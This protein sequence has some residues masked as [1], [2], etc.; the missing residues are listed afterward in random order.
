MHTKFA[1]ALIRLGATNPE[2]RPHIRPLLAAVSIRVT[3]STIDRFRK[4]Q[5]FSTLKGAQAFAQKW[6]GKTPEM[7][8]YYAVSGDGVGKIEVLGVPIEALF[9]NSEEGRDYLRDQQRGPPSYGHAP[10]PGEENY[11]DFVSPGFDDY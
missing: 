1:E 4:S 9:P 2:L 10:R 3:Y 11:E 6:V 5:S 7:G 8:G